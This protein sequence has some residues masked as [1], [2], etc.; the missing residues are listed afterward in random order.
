[1]ADLTVTASN[2]VPAS[3]VRIKQAVADVAITAGQLF[4]ID[5]STSG[6]KLV[7]VDA[8]AA[9]ATIKGIAVS[10]C[11]A[12]Q[13]FTYVDVGN[14]AMGT[15]LTAGHWYYGSDT[16]GGIKPHADL[17]QGDYSSCIGFAASTSVLT[18]GITNTGVALA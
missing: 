4:Y 18:V 3:G 1:M 2:V 6:A 5:S 7:D 11:S 17:V 13:P 9:A 15:I 12:N 8:S 16:A 14:V 10:S